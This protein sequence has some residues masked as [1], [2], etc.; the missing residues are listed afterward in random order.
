MNQFSLETGFE[1]RNLK[2]ERAK[3]FLNHFGL[4]GIK[5]AGVS[6]SVSYTPVE[7]DDIDIF[8]ISSNGKLWP[9]LLRAFV[10]RR[11][12][13]MDD[14]CISLTMDEKFADEMFSQ[15]GDYLLASDSYHVIPLIGKN[16]YDSLLSK[17]PFIRSYIPQWRS[18][19]TLV[20]TNTGPSAH[21]LNVLL[22]MILAPFIYIKTA[23]N[24]KK[25]VLKVGNE[26]RYRAVLGIHKFYLDT[27]K[28]HDL[29]EKLSGGRHA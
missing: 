28:Y 29:K 17:S 5:F 13:G 6:G 8:I 25:S 24:E 27:Q 4:K 23:R 9:V 14:I 16:Y 1:I 2:L 12:L 19:S 21:I 22:F 18:E 3:I 7:S 15:E 20:D 26:G 11:M 10:L